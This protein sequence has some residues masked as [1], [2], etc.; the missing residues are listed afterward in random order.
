MNP[1]NSPSNLP[2]SWAG[3]LA[4]SF[5]LAGLLGS[6]LLLGGC[7]SWANNPDSL[8]SMISPHH[9]DVQQGNVITQE[10]VARLKPGMNRLQV[11]DVMGTP[12][13]ADTFHANRWDYVFTLRQ[14][15]RTVQRHNVVLIFDGDNLKTV[16]APELPT[17]REFFGGDNSFGV[18]GDLRAA[19]ALAERMMTEGGQTPAERIGFFL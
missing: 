4:W 10:Q 5:R 1:A 15:G 6:A 3:R 9:L 17:E 13:L 14:G 2:G 12:L 18:G 16:T 8:L 7:S 11:R 19:T